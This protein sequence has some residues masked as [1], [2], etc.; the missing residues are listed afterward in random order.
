MVSNNLALSGM[1][2]PSASPQFSPGL[3]ANSAGGTSPL[4]V[5]S[6]SASTP[7]ASSLGSSPLSGDLNS[8][9]MQV[10]MMFMMMMMQM[11]T[12]LM[13]GGSAGSQGADTA[14]QGGNGGASPIGGNPTAEE[15]GPGTDI[16]AMTQHP[17]RVQGLDWK[18]DEANDCGEA[19]IANAAKL[20]GKNLSEQQVLQFAKSH[21]LANA[22]LTT[23]VNQR[24]QILS[25]L[26]VNSTSKAGASLDDVAREAA[27]GNSV[28]MS[29]NNNA[30][31]GQGQGGP[32][33]HVVTVAGVK[34]SPDGKV[35]GFY[36]AD[37]S[38]G[39]KDGLRFVGMSQLQAA[40][41]G[42]TDIN[43]IRH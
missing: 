19:S 9:M 21:H 41:G 13:G 18:Q 31:L 2:S 12:G 32:E 22:D 6:S 40:T 38:S 34:K 24:Q 30:I 8:S 39:D 25:G 1:R 35:L 17:D 5:S 15:S 29:V 20:A 28:I 33:N 16:G 14:F 36:I 4:A 26:G 23:N 43:V 42:K 37:T 7:S 3:Q 27:A 11:L 10:M